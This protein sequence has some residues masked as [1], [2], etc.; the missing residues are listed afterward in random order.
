GSQ[1]TSSDPEMFAAAKNTIRYRLSHGGGH[2]GWSRAW[3]IC[4]WARLQ[5]GDE[6][7]EN[8]RKLLEKSTLP[9]LFD[10]HP[11]FQI[12]GNFG[13]IAG[14]A[15]ILL[16]SHEGCLRLLP[17]LPSA[18]RKGRVRGLRARGGYTVDIAWD[19]GRY[20]ARILSDHAG[21]LRLEDGR[22]VPHEAHAVITLHSESPDLTVSY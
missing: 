15:E 20:E 14:M 21:I 12:D 9:N 8:I 1:I 13:S 16:Q 4:M 2:T 5:E 11:P 6:A 17:A 18:W 3:I 7:W 22:T 10:N 19:N